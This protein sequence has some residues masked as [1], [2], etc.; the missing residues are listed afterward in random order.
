MMKGE[1]SD[2]S[3]SGFAALSPLPRTCRGEN[4]VRFFK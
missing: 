3:V 1:G 2:H 4:Y